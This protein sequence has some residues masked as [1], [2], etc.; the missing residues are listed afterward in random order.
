[1]GVLVRFLVGVYTK[2]DFYQNRMTP[3]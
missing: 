1:V 2:S 3:V